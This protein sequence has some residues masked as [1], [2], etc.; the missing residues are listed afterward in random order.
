LKEIT[1]EKQKKNNLRTRP[2]QTNTCLRAALRRK[3]EGNEE[4]EAAAAAVGEAAA[5]AVGEAA[6]PDS[7]RLSTLESHTTAASS[8]VQ[9]ILPPS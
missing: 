1:D 2:L 9:Q 8:Q 5:A 7:E 6:P 3:E 4:L